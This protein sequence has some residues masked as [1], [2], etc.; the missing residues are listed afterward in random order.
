MLQSARMRV[1]RALF[2]RKFVSREHAASLS[3]FSKLGI[4]V[5]TASLPITAFM[6][7]DKLAELPP[8]FLNLQLPL[9]ARFHVR[10]ALWS[11]NE[12]SGE[13][14]D[15]LARQLDLALQAVL[16]SGL[17]A[18]SPESTALVLFLSR[19]YL[20]APKTAPSDLEAS[21][22][23]LIFKPHVGESIREERSRLSL[24][25]LVADRLCKIYAS[26]Q[27]SDPDKV[28]YY[29]S[30]SLQLLDGGPSYLRAEWTDHPLRSVFRQYLATG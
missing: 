6:L 15:E 17:G 13:G 26:P 16:N 14:I 30:K 7:Y 3:S 22:A 11:W 23:A 12:R 28:R 25:F 19:C 27:C 1:F 20:E 18:A 10:R 21:H 5:G 29:A 24:S 4:F 2:N 8:E 9:R